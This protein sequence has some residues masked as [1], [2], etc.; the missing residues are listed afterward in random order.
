M[1]REIWI[2]TEEVWLVRRR[3][4]VEA[5]CAA[6]AERVP[7]VTEADGAMLSGQRL[8][9]I[10]QCLEAGLLHFAQT[11]DGTLVCLTSLLNRK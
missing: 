11:A 3:R 5:W 2:E 9:E 4:L 8:D 6:C 1:R 10:R 7:H